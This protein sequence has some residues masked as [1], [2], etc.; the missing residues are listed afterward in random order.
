MEAT[1]VNLHIKNFVRPLTVVQVRNLLEQT[2][3]PIF[4]WMDDIKSQCYVVASSLEEAIATHQA[5]HEKVWPAETGKPLQVFYVP[6][7]EL[8]QLQGEFKSR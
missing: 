2:C 3:N 8:P 5:L 4:F 7:S 1:S 6:R